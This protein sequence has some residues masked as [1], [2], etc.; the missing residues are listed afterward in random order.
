MLALCNY[1]ER[2][3]GDILPLRAALT[4]LSAAG[5]W[6]SNPNVNIHKLVMRLVQVVIRYSQQLKDDLQVRVIEII[7]KLILE[8]AGLMDHGTADPAHV[9]SCV[10]AAVEG[11]VSSIPAISVNQIQ[12]LLR[13][14]CDFLDGSAFDIRMLIADAPADFRLEGVVK[15]HFASTRSLLTMIGLGG[16]NTEVMERLRTLCVD[17]FQCLAAYLLNSLSAEPFLC[18]LVEVLLN[19]FVKLGL[20]ETESEGVLSILQSFKYFKCYNNFA[21]LFA[22]ISNALV[23]RSRQ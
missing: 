12:V 2:A 16:G 20:M 22:P 7:M 10:Q 8:W 3:E 21:M 23:V 4:A 5:D 15:E 1:C 13:E 6:A 14:V 11:I 18:N 9:R 17:Y 19:L